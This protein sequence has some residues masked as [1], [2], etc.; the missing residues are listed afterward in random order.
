MGHA[1]AIALHSVDL[2]DTLSQEQQA[3]TRL[4]PNVLYA[5]SE[6]APLRLRCADILKCYHEAPCNQT[7]NYFISYREFCTLFCIECSDE[8]EFMM[9]QLFFNSVRDRAV[10]YDNRG[11]DSKR[12]DRQ[13][14]S[15]FL[16]MLSLIVLSREDDFETKIESSFHLFCLNHDEAALSVESLNLFV[17]TLLQCISVIV[18]GQSDMLDIPLTEVVAE[19]KSII[20]NSKENETKGDNISCNTFCTFCKNNCPANVE[21]ILKLSSELD[22]EASR[23]LKLNTDTNVNP[24]RNLEQRFSSHP[25]KELERTEG[26]I[27]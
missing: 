8:H 24:L 10:I 7:G 23:V 2:D 15:F 22:P 3:I 27:D 20:V 13:N 16:L 1:L 19:V 4:D 9:S 17:L 12:N 21:R 11:R 25:P 5:Y 6:I 18:Y 14:A 26:G